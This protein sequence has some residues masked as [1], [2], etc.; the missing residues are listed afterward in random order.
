MQRGP[1]GAL[2]SSRSLD[3]NHR[4]ALGTLEKLWSIVAPHVASLKIIVLA[5]SC[6]V[7]LAHIL[8][9]STDVRAECLLRQC[10]VCVVCVCVYFSFFVSSGLVCVSV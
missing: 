4:P 3:L 8:G 2:S 5:T 9:V 10:V 6:T 7:G 1:A